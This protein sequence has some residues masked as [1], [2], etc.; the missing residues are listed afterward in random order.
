MMRQFCKTDIKDI[1]NKLV[2]V[3]KKALKK[4]DYNASAKFIREA[5]KWAYNTNIFYYEPELE[6]LLKTLSDK[7]LQ[8]KEIIPNNN[9]YIL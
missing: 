5:A 4:N 7:Y 8:K 2:D 6:I 1:Y 3:A 9:K